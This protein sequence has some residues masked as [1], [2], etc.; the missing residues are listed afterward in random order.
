MSFMSYSYIKTSPLNTKEKQRLRTSIGTELRLQ[1][2]I[3]NPSQH[4]LI[5]FLINLC[6]DPLGNIHDEAIDWLL[7]YGR[8]TLIKKFIDALSTIDTKNTTLNT[9]KYGNKDHILLRDYINPDIQKIQLQ[10]KPKT[11]LIC[12]TGGAHKLNMPIQLFHFLAAHRFDLIFYLRDFTQQAF[13]SGISTIASNI[14]ELSVVLRESIPPDCSIAVLGASTGGYAS[15]CLSEAIPI[16]RLALFSSPF[17]FNGIPAMHQFR[18]PPEQ[19]KLY[20]AANNTMD[21]KFAS[22]WAN[23]KDVSSLRWIITDTH[24]TLRY[25]FLCGHLDVLFNWLLG[26]SAS[27]EDINMK[28]KP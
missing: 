3:Q 9:I 10:A 16:N 11:A 26:I 18:I 4:I 2:L 5:N 8:P 21:N 12:F 6:K 25:L 20:F 27:M 19:V 7:S 15:A 14:H 13:T 28:D 22:R 17:L 23:T 24:G 1:H